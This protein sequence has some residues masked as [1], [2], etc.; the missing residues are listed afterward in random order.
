MERKTERQIRRLKESELADE[1]GAARRSLD[2]AQDYADLLRRAILDR[3][4]KSAI[5]QRWQIKVERKRRESYNIEAILKKFGDARLES[6]KRI[7]PYDAIEVRR[8]GN[9][10]R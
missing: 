3:K 6:C 10:E 2:R 5:G 9:I 7:T 8:V 1:I 4:I